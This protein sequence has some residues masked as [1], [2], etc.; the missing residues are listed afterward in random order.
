MERPDS[1]KS[2][3]M[4]NKD[5]FM[6]RYLFPTVLLFFVACTELP[7]GRTY[8]SEM[9]HDDSTFYRPDEDFPVVGGDAEVAGMSM[10]EYRRNRMPKSEEDKSY[11]R[12]TQ[13][14]RA[15]LKALEG[16]QS[17]EEMDFYQ[18]YRKRFANTSEKIYYLKLPRS[19]R[20]QYLQERGFINTPA[21]RAPASVAA[22]GGGFQPRRNQIFMGMTKNDVMGSFGKP[23]RVEVA[24]NPSNENERWMYNINGSSKYVYFESG[25]VQGWE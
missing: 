7:T 13:V 25:V 16:A 11:D 10:D 19:E 18:K 3:V 20:R 6:T 23:S 21:T 12:E 22:A 24:G 9:E 14:L 5:G 1:E 17:E 15:E 2:L 4:R 8:L